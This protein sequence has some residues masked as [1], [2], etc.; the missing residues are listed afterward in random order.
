MHFI[1]NIR[2]VFGCFALLVAIN[3]YAGEITPELQAELNRLAPGGEVA[4]IIRFKEP[5]NAKAFK[6][7]NRRVRRERMI[8]ALKNKA[9]REQREIQGLLAIQG[10]KRERELWLINGRSA[11]VPARAV[12][13]IARN[14]RVASVDLD[15]EITLSGVPASCSISPAGWN[16]NAVNAADLWALGFDGSGVVVATMDSGADPDHP[17]TALSWRGGT[18]S[19]YDPNGEHSS[20]YDANG[21]GTWALG[22]LVGG[23]AGGASIGMAPGAQ[24][25]SAKVFDDSGTATLSAIHAAFQWLLDPD[26]NPA[27]NDAADV[28]NNSWVLDGSVDQCDN[29]FQNDIDALKIADIAVVFSAG[30]SGPGSATS[31][32]PANDP[33]SIAVGSAGEAFGTL[34][35]AGASARGPS[36]CDAGV[37]PQL[38]APGAN[39]VTADRTLGGIFPDSYTCVSGT[40]FA[41]PH[42]A[43]AIALL[44]SAMDSS[45]LSV[46]VS[47]LETSLL[48][49]AVDMGSAGPDNDWGAGL[50]DVVGAYNWLLANAGSPQPG[51]LQFSAANYSTDEDVGDIMITVSRSGGTAGDVTVDYNTSDGSATAGDDYAAT[52][53]TLTFLDGE[54]SQTFAVG[55]VDD[56]D[57]ENDEQLNLALSNATGG[58]TIGSTSSSTI[59]IIDNDAPSGPVDA[60]NDGYTNDVDCN[61]NDPSIHPGAPEIKHDGVDQ[62]CNGYD[63]TIDITRARFV[64]AKD[65]V[66]V[67]ATSDLGSQAGLQ[68]TVQLAGGG[69]VSK[70]MVWKA[71]KNRWQKTI[72]KF[73]RKYGSPTTATVSGAE[74]SESAQVDYR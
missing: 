10:A 4:V 58:A 14:R 35:V 44:K 65:K 7:K 48:Q 5:V 41:A 23:N 45:G 8:R 20:P 15:R 19:W 66:I 21:H 29:E 56:A 30:N 3:S 37:F 6:D 28:V 52:A 24:W 33:Q 11:Q 2:N 73:T 69:S 71:S 13:R 57:D 46:T 72:G 62:D 1:K 18:N 74:G 50:L 60:D 47:Q 38:V 61:D 54:T 55:I 22:L 39:V 67:W 27:T 9:N 53:G 16:L 32:S 64:S 25:I 59:T 31:M 51:A 63:L 34:Y 26:G 68:L 42:V 17:D 12:A 70:N 36:A 49:G 43:G 40:S